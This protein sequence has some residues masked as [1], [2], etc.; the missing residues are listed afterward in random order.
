MAYFQTQNL[1]VFYSLK[2]V[3]D[4]T[5]RQKYSR[6]KFAWTKPEGKNRSPDKCKLR[7]FPIAPGHS[8][9]IS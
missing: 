9:P 2:P 8:S 1:A 6:V 4:S 7:P 3:I 5:Y